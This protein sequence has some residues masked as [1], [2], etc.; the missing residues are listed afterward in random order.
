MRHL[1]VTDVVIIQ[2]SKLEMGPPTLKLLVGQ[3]GAMVTL[4]TTY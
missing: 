1:L 2:Y 3:L 4:R